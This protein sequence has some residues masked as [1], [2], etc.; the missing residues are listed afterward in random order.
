MVRTIKP[1]LPST[2]L[3]VAR[4]L[5]KTMTD[6]ERRLWKHLRAGRLCGLKFRRQH[7]VPPYVVDFC[8]IEAALAVELDGSQ[9]N[10]L[11]DAERTRYLQAQ[12]WRVVRYWNNEVL[13]QIDAVLE[14]IERIARSRTLSPTPLPEGE[15]L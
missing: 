3:E 10:A 11:V 5:R 4:S 1:P 15:G 7:P 2:T 14:E 13:L 12:G 6:A 9:H 8:C